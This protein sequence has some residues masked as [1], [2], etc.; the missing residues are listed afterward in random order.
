MS[1][2]REEQKSEAVKRMRA[3]KM[4]EQPIQEFEGS[5]TLNLSENNG[6]LYWLDK[7]EKSMVSKF[8]TEND[9]LVYHVIKSYTSM[10]LMY[11][12]L[13]VSSYPEEWETDMEDI[14]N[15]EALAYVVNIN[16]PDCSEFGS[17]GI[18]PV[19]GGVQRTW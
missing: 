5:G 16:M 9:C 8:E 18:E 4:L 19:N 17:I 11:S 13:Y 3:L 14:K 10:G 6:M 15:E 12:L 2:L 1:D 7:N